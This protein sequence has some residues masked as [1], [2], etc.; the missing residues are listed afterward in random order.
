MTQR[1]AQRAAI[2]RL[3]VADMRQRGLQQRAVLANVRGKF[4]VA[5]ARHG[6]DF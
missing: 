5:L 3:P 6:A 2:T 4:D 1:A